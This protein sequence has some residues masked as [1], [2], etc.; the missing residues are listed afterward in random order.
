[1]VVKMERDSLLT[2]VQL[3]LLPPSPLSN[4]A[5]RSRMV[6]DCGTGPLTEHCLLIVESNSQYQL[7]LS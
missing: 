2:V 1:M 5:M 3:Q 4:A 6:A 7:L